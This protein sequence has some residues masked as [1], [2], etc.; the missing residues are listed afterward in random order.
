VQKTTKIHAAESKSDETSSPPVSQEEKS[1][2]FSLILSSWSS[3]FSSLNSSFELRSRVTVA[4]LSSA[5]PTDSQ[6]IRKWKNTLCEEVYASYHLFFLLLK[7]KEQLLSPCAI[8]HLDEIFS[9]QEEHQAQ[10]LPLLAFIAL[11]EIDTF[12]TLCEETS[13]SFELSEKA[14]EWVEA[15]WNLFS[16]RLENLYMKTSPS[17]LIDPQEILATRYPEVVADF[18]LLPTGELF[19]PFIPYFVEQCI[20]T[21]SKNSVKKHVI[22]NLKFAAESQSLQ[23]F[24]KQLQ[25]SDENPNAEI[26]LKA[27]LG[28]EID[29]Q[30][31]HRDLALAYF[32]TF[33][34]N[35]RQLESGACF[36]TSLGILLCNERQLLFAKDLKDLVQTGKLTRYLGKQKLEF[37]YLLPLKH[38][39]LERPLKTNFTPLESA[40]QDE[41]ECESTRVIEDESISFTEKESFFLHPAFGRLIKAL[42]ER[43]KE[44]LNIAFAR[45]ANQELF[46]P[47]ELFSSLIE[48]LKEEGVQEE[49]LEVYITWSYLSAFQN[50]LLLCWESSVAEMAEAKERGMIMR[51]VL[52]SII[53]PIER[54]LETHPSF[55]KAFCQTLKIS[56]QKRARVLWDPAVFRFKVGS[57]EHLQGGFILYDNNKFSWTRVDNEE[58]FRLF[59]SSLVE[60]ALEAAPSI[61][62]DGKQELFS[63]LS[64]SRYSIDALIQYNPACQSAAEEGKVDAE[65]ILHAPWRTISGNISENVLKVYFE[66]KGLSTIRFSVDAVETLFNN[67]VNFALE[68]QLST[69]KTMSR[70]PTSVAKHAFTTI[71]QSENTLNLNKVSQDRQKFLR[72]TKECAVFFHSCPLLTS[73]KERI[74]ELFLDSLPDLLK[75]RVDLSSM[76]SHGKTF[77]AF[78]EEIRVYLRV[79]FP[80]KNGSNIEALFKKI[81]IENL[82]EHLL[83]PLKSCALVFADSNWSQEGQN[84]YFCFSYDPFTNGLGIYEATE[85]FSHFSSFL[86]EELLHTNWAITQIL[87]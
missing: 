77:N 19:T 42:G 35:I 1:T 67:L 68:M 40:Y 17:S 86:S 36:A 44:S 57:K 11:Q 54:W 63:Y 70:C 10:I 5:H 55:P 82:P 41:S 85:D 45:I 87:F 51:P 59:V 71:F 34:T 64:S 69:R 66:E 13:T 81:L 47:K 46:S 30:I 62:D 15:R 20:P 76:P 9:H 22:N 65:H 79:R 43:R 38:K 75:Q 31:T 8:A 72:K 6:L 26:I 80:G 39:E 53:R 83:C 60:E 37:P 50:P 14:K 24:I 25:I 56:L 12:E 3:L 48:V 58:L 2:F 28:K 84:L 73:W 49:G 52:Y 23:L 74:L 4:P 61:S 7:E 33:L 32:S 21:P 78:F 18:L 27:W 16:E 29:S